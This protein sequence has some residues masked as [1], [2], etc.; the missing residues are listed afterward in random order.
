M[1]RGETELSHPSEHLTATDSVDTTVN[2]VDI[3]NGTQTV[4]ETNAVV[5]F[6]NSYSL[7]LNRELV[8]SRIDRW[9]V[10]SK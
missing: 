9:C 4:F 5:E 7:F 3:T 2:R 10:F 1:G 6:G 8:K